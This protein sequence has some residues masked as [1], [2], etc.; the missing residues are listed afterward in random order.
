M[1]R[2]TSKRGGLAPPLLL[3]YSYLEVSLL[4][5]FVCG[6]LESRTPIFLPRGFTMKDYVKGYKQGKEDYQKNKEPSYSLDPSEDFQRGYNAGWDVAK[7]AYELREP[8][9]TV[10]YF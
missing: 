6:S 2:S 1:F 4:D 8:V 9:D 3:W 5:N 7:N 10:D